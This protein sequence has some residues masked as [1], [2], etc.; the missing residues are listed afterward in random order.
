MC[1]HLA[2]LGAPRSPVWP[3]FEAPHSLL[4]QSYAP[5]DMRYGGTVNADGF[6]LAWFADHGKPVRHRRASPLWTD[7]TL[8]RLAET[9]SAGTF[10]AAVRSATTGMPV[11]DGACAPFA[12]EHWLFSH[13][14]V[15]R[16]WPD[17]VA[18]LA[19]KLPVTELLRMEA[20][21]DSALLWTL[22]RH[23]LR[24]GT[25]PAGAVA[26]LVAD[27]ARAAPGSRLNLLLAGPD[28]VI[29]T[30]WTHALSVLVT[31]E[32]VLIASEPLDD[33]P[34]WSPVPD[35]HLVLARRGQPPAVEAVEAI[36]LHTDR[37]HP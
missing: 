10:V 4:V 7:E 11:A 32:G 1:R 31:D 26:G 21:T 13:N 24:E 16:G 2:Y 34:R 6:G 5:R 23:R 9:V 33:D 37:S 22:L 25:D 17:S 3:V 35:Q 30:A 28:L 29:A 14:G 15:V 8:P 36:A 12:D 19:E 27:V 20:A 18:G